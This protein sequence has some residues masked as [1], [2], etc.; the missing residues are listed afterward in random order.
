MRMKGA[1]LARHTCEA[2]IDQNGNS[3]HQSLQEAMGE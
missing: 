2:A 1:T 3:D